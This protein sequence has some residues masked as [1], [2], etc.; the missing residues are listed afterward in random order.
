MPN[1][2]SVIN[3]SFSFVFFFY[4]FQFSS[5]LSIKTTMKIIIS[6]KIIRK[7]KKF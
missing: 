3:D 4:I 1:N 5:I 2:N 7:N 6:K